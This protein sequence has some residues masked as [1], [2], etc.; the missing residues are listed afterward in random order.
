MTTGATTGVVTATGGL[1]IVTGGQVDLPDLLNFFKTIAI[2]Q[3]SGG[4]GG[5]IVVQGN[6]TDD[7]TG[8]LNIGTVAGISGI[9]APGS[10]VTLINVGTTTQDTGAAAAI[11]VENLIL[12]GGT[13]GQYANYIYFDNGAQTYPSGNPNVVGSGF[14]GFTGAF[15]L[16]NTS[17]AIS[18]IAGAVGS[19]SLT[20]SAS[21][22]ISSLSDNYTATTGTRDDVQRPYRLL[23]PGADERGLEPD[24][25]GHDRR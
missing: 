5:H 16:N 9:S 19:L 18:H 14:N 23:Q 2:K 1:A 15:T 3:L 25:R 17:N 11:N 13:T 10:S 4:V 20:D 21:L 6:S 8:F 24:R 22:T 7:N 12:E